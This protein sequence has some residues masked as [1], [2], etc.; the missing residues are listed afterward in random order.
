MAHYKS[1]KVYYTFKQPRHEDM[2]FIFSDNIIADTPEHAVREGLANSFIFDQ[3][4]SHS[5]KLIHWE[6]FE[7]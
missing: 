1:Y 7:K 3:L 2:I 4:R 6:V 5:I